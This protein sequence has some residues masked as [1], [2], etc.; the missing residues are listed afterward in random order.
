MILSSSN[1]LST[2]I[3][4]GLSLVFAS[5]LHSAII[6]PTINWEADLDTTNN[7]LWESSVNAGT[8]TPWTF[9]ASTSPT[10]ISA[11]T[12]GTNFSAVQSTYSF[13]PITATRPDW[14][15]GIPGGGGAGIDATF[16]LVFR[17]GTATGN[18]VLFET[19]G[20]NMGT[21][22]TLSGTTLTFRSQQGTADG[23]FATIDLPN[24]TVG[25]FHQIV[26]TIDMTTDVITQTQLFH[27]GSLV[28]FDGPADDGADALW[29]GS[30][31]AGLGRV[32]G[33]VTTGTYANFDGDI[34]IMR[35][36][37]DD[38]FDLADAQQ[39]FAALAIPEPTTSTLAALSLLAL[40]ARRRRA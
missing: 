27:N 33:S 31:D 36:Y 29:D 30:D 38:V 18:Q 14:G 12:A 4:A 25:T 34:A 9:S 23:T 5:S 37:R 3:T 20:G 1:S 7:N 35:Y 39:N 11:D 13:S 22:I 40:A 17:L 26:A 6:A 16:E 2:S 21:A 8:A 10:D 28:G 24:L 32:N 19:G 15:G